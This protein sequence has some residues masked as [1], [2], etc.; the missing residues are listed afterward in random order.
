MPFTAEVT[1]IFFESSTTT[2]LFGELLYITHQIN[3][4]GNIIE[5]DYVAETLTG[6][7]SGTWRFNG[8]PA[9][10]PPDRGAGLRV[11][12]SANAAGALFRSGYLDQ[13]PVD[14]TGAAALEIVEGPWSLVTNADIPSFGT[15][16]SV[17]GSPPV[18]VTSVAIGIQEG[19][20]WIRAE[21]TTT[22]AVL[23][24]IAWRFRGDLTLSPAGSLTR[25]MPQIAFDV[26]VSNGELELA[27]AGPSPAEASVILAAI[28][29]II[30]PT[31]SN[32]VACTVERQ[33]TTATIAEVGRRLSR[34]SQVIT[35][36]TDIVLS[37]DRVVVGTFRPTA[38]SQAV[39]GVH[40]LGAL[41]SF[42]GVIGRLF[43]QVSSGGRGCRAAMLTPAAL[44]ALGAAVAVQRLRHGW[45][46]S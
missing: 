22:A 2:T 12:R 39:L 36:P 29:P 27:S 9:P 35:L 5:G 19:S 45:P 21:G 7:I 42:G 1:S 3:P 43:P 30:T 17:P 31:V 33:L 25:S 10:T 14:S 34:P 8:E 23:G 15:P 44:A 13:I 38:A 40:V 16:F 37:V 46:G 28:R 32:R 26:Q 11:R 18:E 20:I 24:L 41:G 4:S 6:P